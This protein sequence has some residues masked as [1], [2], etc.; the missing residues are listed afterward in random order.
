[1]CMSK[2]SLIVLH[3]SIV[4]EIHHFLQTLIGLHTGSMAAPI[5]YKVERTRD[6]HM[7]ATRHVQAI[8]NGKIMFTMYASFQVDPLT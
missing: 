1:M 6:G 7:F 8:Q 4:G 5:M 2:F 3:K